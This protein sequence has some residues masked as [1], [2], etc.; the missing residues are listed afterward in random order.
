[1][2]NVDLRPHESTHATDERRTS[3]TARFIRAECRISTSIAD[4]G[5]GRKGAVVQ[6]EV[7][8]SLTPVWA[9]QDRRLRHRNGVPRTGERFDSVDRARS[10]APWRS[11][12]H[13][14]PDRRREQRFG[15]DRTRITRAPCAAAAND[16]CPASI[17]R[18]GASG[19][20]N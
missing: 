3:A 4:I 20:T 5:D 14:G 10:A 19:S 2:P 9:A 6:P 15:T 11:E 13:F 17:S 8:L 12:Q 1:M 16:G 7:H 18:G